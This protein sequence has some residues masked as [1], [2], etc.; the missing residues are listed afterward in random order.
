MEEDLYAIVGVKEFATKEEITK[1]FRKKAPKIHPDKNPHDPLASEKF[2]RLRHAYETLLN[3]EKRKVFDNVIK[4][5]MEKKK[6]DLAMDDARRK[7]MEDLLAREAEAASKK[8]GQTFQD[9]KQ[10]KQKIMEETEMLRQKFKRKKEPHHEENLKKKFNQKGTEQQNTGS[11]FDLPPHIN[12]EQDI[13]QKLRAKQKAAS[14][15][16]SSSSPAPTPTAAPSPSFS[17]DEILQKLRKKQQQQQEK[18]QEDQQQEEKKVQPE[19]IIV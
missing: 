14:S 2:Q 5:K 6:R 8:K 9:D 12:N 3:D 1:A 19:I 18:Q 10:A 15:S 4:A 17:E 7:M 13:L 11:V 16:S